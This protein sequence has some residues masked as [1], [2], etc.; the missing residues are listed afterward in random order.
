M[1]FCDSNIV[2][3]PISSWAGCE[4]HLILASEAPNCVKILWTSV[5][6]EVDL[7]EAAHSFNI[8]L[9]LLMYEALMLRRAWLHTVATVS[10]IFHYR[11]QGGH[12]GRL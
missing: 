4:Q 10:L 3:T 7:I 11:M 12:P 2:T 6:N 1:A 9:S 5:G 8:H